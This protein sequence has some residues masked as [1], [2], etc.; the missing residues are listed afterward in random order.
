MGVDE[1]A[2]CTVSRLP[3]NGFLPRVLGR[4][5]RRRAFRDEGRIARDGA[6]AAPADVP[7]LVSA[8]LSVR[9]CDVSP[10]EGC[11]LMGTIE[12][13]IRVGVPALDRASAARFA[14]DVQYYLTLT[15]RQLPSRY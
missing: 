4:L 7:Q 12:P 8:A 2:V 5:L 15:P 10:R 6:R 11:R 13:S 9:V 14:A 1:H 3:A